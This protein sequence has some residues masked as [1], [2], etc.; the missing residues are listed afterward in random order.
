MIVGLINNSLDYVSYLARPS[1]FSVTWRQ[2]QMNE[3]TGLVEP[4]QPL[5][6]Q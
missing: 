3:S 6:G 5:Q 1:I 4:P 2:R